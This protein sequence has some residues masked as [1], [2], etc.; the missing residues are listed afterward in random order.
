MLNDDPNND[1]RNGAAE[2]PANEI[3]DEDLWAA[4]HAKNATIESQDG[5]LRMARN[6]M[7]LMAVAAILS[8]WFSQ[9]TISHYQGALEAERAAHNHE[10]EK[11]NHTLGKYRNALD[12]CTELDIEAQVYCDELELTKRGVDV[13][14]IPGRLKLDRK[15]FRNNW[16][17]NFGEPQKQD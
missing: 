3:T 16:G 2:D 4:I 17:P 7:A 12:R 5:L 14:R 9:R 6:G 11:H 1:D 10:I 8:T 15:P 13:Q